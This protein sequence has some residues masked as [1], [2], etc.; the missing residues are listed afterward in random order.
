MQD[1]V[2]CPSCRIR[3]RLPVEPPPGGMTCPRCLAR[4][5]D[6][7]VPLTSI[8]AT[9]PPVA[10]AGGSSPPEAD[11]PSLPRPTNCPSC[12]KPTE[13]VWMFCPYCEQPIEREKRS[14]SGSGVD[15][16]IK[17]DSVALKIALGLLCVL[18]GIGTL[19]YFAAT[20]ADGRPEGVVFGI[21]ALLFL[22]LISTG[23]MF[24]RTRNNPRERGFG[25]V[26]LGTFT[27]IGIGLATGCSLALAVVVFAFVVCMAG[28]MR[29]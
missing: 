16:D 14:R 25:R 5:H 9:L 4:V 23:I 18:G 29:F 27:L 13:P 26:V 22:G 15:R 24:W 17:R 12:G 3:L 2:T 28:G 19:W 7:S 8:Q 6:P 20:L 21:V 1:T 10:D 11:A